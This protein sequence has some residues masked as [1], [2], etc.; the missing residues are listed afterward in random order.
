M[1]LNVV[2]EAVQAHGKVTNTVQNV[3]LLRPSP[4][5]PGAPQL[6]SPVHCGASH[7]SR[8]PAQPFCV[9]SLQSGTFSLLPDSCGLGV[10]EDR[11]LLIWYCPC[12]GSH[13]QSSCSG[14]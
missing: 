1:H 11:R 12:R 4:G 8:T 6:P 14:G 9:S 5:P 3:P 2:L 7:L 13:P 10:L